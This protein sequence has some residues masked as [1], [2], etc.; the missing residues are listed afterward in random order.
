MDVFLREIAASLSDLV[1]RD[2][3]LADS[4]SS[5]SSSI[6]EAAPTPVQSIMADA[7]EPAAIAEEELGRWWGP[8]VPLERIGQEGRTAAAIAQRAPAPMQRGTAGPA[9]GASAAQR[10]PAP[11]VVIRAELSLRKV[12]EREFLELLLLD[13]A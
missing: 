10:A 12:H 5:F 3:T 4:G 6:T 11:G 2:P 1:L 9:I 8:W 7:A 13:A